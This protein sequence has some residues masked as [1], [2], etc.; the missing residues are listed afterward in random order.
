[1]RHDSVSPVYSVMD[2]HIRAKG[3]F[4]VPFVELIYSKIQERYRSSRKPGMA[5]TAKT[6]NIGT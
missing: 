1:M 4:C 6:L 2:N 3:A 5:P